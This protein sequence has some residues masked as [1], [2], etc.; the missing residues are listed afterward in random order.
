VE[1]VILKVES[2]VMMEIPMIEMVVHQLVKMKHNQFVEMVMQKQVE[3]TQQL[4]Q[5]SVI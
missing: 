3:Q 1:I 5:K 2:N 4:A